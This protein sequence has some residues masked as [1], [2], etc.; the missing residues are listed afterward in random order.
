MKTCFK[1]LKDKPVSEFYKHPQMGDGYLGKCKSCTKKDSNERRML[2]EATNLEWVL[3][4]RARNREKSKKARRQGMSTK[5]DR[6]ESSRK[7][8][9]KFPFKARAHTA[10]ENA[11]RN[12][13]LKPQKCFCGGK[14]QAHHED[15][16]KPLDVVWLCR[17]HHMERH[18]EM[19][20]EI[21]RKKFAGR[22]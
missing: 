13:R 8:R 3:N 6:A 9:L 1:C 20:E 15:Y 19:R 16:S 21:L 4:E 10:V 17:K 22:I 14:A 11:I 12:G 18:V 2:L 5:R 7:F